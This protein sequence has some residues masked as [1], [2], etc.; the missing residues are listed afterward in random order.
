MKMKKFLIWLALDHRSLGHQ[1]LFWIAMVLPVALFL[2]FG[3][4]SWIGSSPQW[5]SKGFSH[6]IEISKLPLG[7]LTLAIPFTALVTSMHR[8][9]QTAKQIEHGESKSENESEERAQEAAAMCL[10][11]AFELL[12]NEGK[13]TRR[14][15]L[16]DAAKDLIND[17]YRI[18]ITINKL[19]IKQQLQTQEKY[20][21]AKLKA[22]LAQ[23][24]QDDFYFIK[25]RGVEESTMIA[26]AKFCNSDVITKYIKASLGKVIYQDESKELKTTYYPKPDCVF[27]D[28]V[29]AGPSDDPIITK[30]RKQR[31]LE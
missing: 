20:W 22:I 7:L 13:S 8:S 3:Y 23:I 28:A 11:K 15:D 18:K 31:G 30:E 17:Y 2:I 6:F 19:E 27:E 12:N 10:E 14:A 25:M 5:D 9:I 1:P 24:S 21:K 4:L 26:I 16:W 29:L